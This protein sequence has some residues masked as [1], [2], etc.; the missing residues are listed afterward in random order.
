MRSVELHA[1]VHDGFGMQAPARY[2]RRSRISPHQRLPQNSMVPICSSLEDVICRDLP[3]V[4]RTMLALGYL[5]NPYL[6]AGRNRLVSMLSIDLQYAL[7]RSTAALQ[8]LTH[9]SSTQF[10][11]IIL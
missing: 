11:A 7:P 5:V 1:R 6:F 9:C 10:E 2:G 3:F 4:V 8:L